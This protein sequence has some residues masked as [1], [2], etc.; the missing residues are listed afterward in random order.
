MIKERL[1]DDFYSQHQQ[2]IAEL[3]QQ[4][5]DAKLSPSQALQQLFK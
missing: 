1:Q 2:Q 5:M 3:E 4:V